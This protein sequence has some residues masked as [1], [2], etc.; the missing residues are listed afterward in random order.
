MK[1]LKTWPSKRTRLTY[2]AYYQLIGAKKWRFLTIIRDKIRP[3]IFAKVAIRCTKRTSYYT[4]AWAAHSVLPDNK[5]VRLKN[6]DVGIG[7]WW[8]KGRMKTGFRI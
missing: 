8:L 6:R 3:F 5:G 7:N 2:V 1:E 4:V